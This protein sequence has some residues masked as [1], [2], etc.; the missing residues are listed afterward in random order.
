MQQL[1]T[2]PVSTGIHQ[3]GSK[4]VL[5]GIRA[6]LLIAALIMSKKHHEQVGFWHNKTKIGGVVFMQ[7]LDEPRGE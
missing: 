2:L 1:V 4:S 3:V 6:K 5:Y 7:S